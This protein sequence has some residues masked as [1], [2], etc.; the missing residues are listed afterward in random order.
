MEFIHRDENSYPVNKDIL[1]YRKKYQHDDGEEEFEESENS[2]VSG[3]NIAKKKNN[4]NH[5]KL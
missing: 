3:R 4:Y 1:K 5:G 2:S